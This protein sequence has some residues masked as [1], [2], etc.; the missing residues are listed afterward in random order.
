MAVEADQSELSGGRSTLTRVVRVGLWIGG[1]AAV[2][3]VLDLLG[4]PV[5][6]WIRKLFKDLRAVPPGAIVGGVVLETLQTAFAAVSWLTILRAAFPRAGLRFRVV[7]ACYATAVGLNAFLPA[8]IG[9]LV[10][11]VMFTSVIAGAT[12]PAIVSGFV[13]QK[14][15]FTVISIACYIY[16]FVSVGG[17][18]SLEG[19]FLSNH[20]GGVVVI[21]VSAIA[22]LVAVGMFL[23]R[24]AGKLREQI[25]NGGA[26]LGQPR[27]FVVGVALPQLASYAARLGVVAVFLAAYSIPVSFHSVVAVTTA[28]SVSK[29]V[30]VTPGGAGVTQALNVA[31]L[32]NETSKENATAYSVGQQL[33]ISA[34]DILFAVGMVAWVFGWSGGKELVRESYATAEVKSDEIKQKR[35]ARRAAR[36]HGRRDPQRDEHPPGATPDS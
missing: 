4:V 29:S 22:L 14:I 33:I 31:V 10:M 15:P 13:I 27:R 9:T 8:N 17:S 19:D 12:F 11:M 3:V 2:I 6:D 1:V 24:R 34:W 32:G 16:L 21:V 36:R 25:K 28:N 5:T 18:L 30:Q 7:L 35:A 23:W 26:V 20:P